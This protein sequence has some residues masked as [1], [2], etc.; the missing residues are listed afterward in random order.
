VNKEAIKTIRSV[1]AGAKKVGFL[2]H[3]IRR[4]PTLKSSNHNPTPNS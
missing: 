1:E 3:I 2:Y 4:Y